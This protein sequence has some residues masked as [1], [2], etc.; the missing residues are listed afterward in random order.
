MLPAPTI[1]DGAKVICFT[2]VD[3]RHHPTGKCRHIVGSIV[4]G[5]AAGLAI[6]RDHN[7]AG[8][9]LFGC[10]ESWNSITDGWHQ[11][12]EEAK[13]QA[14]F[15]YTGVSETWQ[16]AARPMIRDR[17]V[18]LEVREYLSSHPTELVATGL[19]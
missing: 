13:R 2:P 5:P 1:I 12:V 4:A 11:T 7:D 17:H 18:Q 8:Y 3:Q 9:Y 16:E 14:E 10:D 19:R 15:E 6:C